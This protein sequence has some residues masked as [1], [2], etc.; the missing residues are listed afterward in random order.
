MSEVNRILK[1][2]AWARTELDTL[3]QDIR[4][5]SE[6]QWTRAPSARPD[7]DEIKRKNV[8]PDPTADTALDPKRLGVRRSV[9]EADRDL[10]K[11]LNLM[12]AMSGRIQQ[13]LKRWEGPK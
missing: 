12:R 4:R 2:I 3:E 9:K 10:L 1:H 6:V 8:K 5:A 13:S 7:V 11:V